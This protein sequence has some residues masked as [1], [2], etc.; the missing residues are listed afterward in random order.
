MTRECVLKWL[1]APSVYH[2]KRDD[3]Y[4]L[5]DRSFGFL[6]RCSSAKGCQSEDTEFMEYCLQEGILT[7]ENTPLK[8]P[9]LISSSDP[10]L[11]YLELQITDK[12]NLKCKHCYIDGSSGSELSL[13]Q[14]ED[15]LS[16]FEEMQGLRVL[17]TG[18][19][20]L[21]H[22]GFDEINEM[23]P[24]FFIRKVLLTNGLLLSRKLLKGLNVEEV[25]ISV[26][27]LRD[28]HDAIR[29]RGT[30]ARAIEAIRLSVECGFDVSVAT[31]VHP[32]NLADFDDMERLFKGLGVKDWTVDVPCVTGRLV[33]HSE[34]QISAAE[35]GRYLGYGYGSGYHGDSSGFA[36]GLHLM[37]VS[38]DGSVS[39]CTFYQP[40]GRIEDGLMN[41]WERIKPIRLDELKC[42]CKYIETCRGGCRYRAELLG[43]SL[44]KDFYRC[45]FYGINNKN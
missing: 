7:R 18:G 30:F 38:A 14:I 44:G 24:R 26:D 31:M 13:I 3:L 8:R 39:K 23:L 4:E 37:A 33:A 40:V 20:P 1:E 28:A 32:G 22:A 41:C 9:A 19:E 27:G 2:I 43:D 45:Y 25:Q 16:Q 36:C 21:L 6:Q 11:R 10:S 29:G 34:F 17:I 42:D 12:C 35:G 5:D 15:V